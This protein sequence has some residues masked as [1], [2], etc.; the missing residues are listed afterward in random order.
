MPGRS[1]LPQRTYPP[2]NSNAMRPILPTSLYL[3]LLTPA[4]AAAA[5]P[6]SEL[7]VPSHHLRIFY[8]A[9]PSPRVT[10]LKHVHTPPCPFP[11]ALP[12]LAAAPVPSRRRLAAALSP[13]IRTRFAPPPHATF[14][15]RLATRRSPRTSRTHCPLASCRLPRYRSS[16]HARHRPRRPSLTS[17][18]RR[19]LPRASGIISRGVPIAYTTVPSPVS[20]SLPQPT[21]L[22]SLP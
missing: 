22:F 12:A 17:R 11:A 14:P 19:L 6:F 1:I 9:T 3:V 4:V 10:P 5:A 20:G 18:P 16:L 21:Y 7:R 15:P 13:H 8:P 2:H